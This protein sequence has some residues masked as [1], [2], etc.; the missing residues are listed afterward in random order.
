MNTSPDDIAWLNESRMLSVCGLPRSTFQSW[1]RNGLE[2]ANAQGAYGL[3]EVIGVALLVEMRRYVGVEDLV[4]VWDDLGAGDSLPALVAKARA[5]QLGDRLDVILEPE[6]GRATIAC[7]DSE[8]AAA[9]RH[10]SAP[11]PIIVLD[12]AERVAHVTATFHRLAKNAPRPQEKRPGR[13][14]RDRKQLRLVDSGG[15]G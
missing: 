3:Y 10:P 8:L 15:G 14:K 13:P 11:R 7:G 1:G 4:A 5:L 6:H 9:V 2:L 12:V